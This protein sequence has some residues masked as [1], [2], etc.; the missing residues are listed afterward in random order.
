MKTARR[1]VGLSE[2]VL[3]ALDAIWANKLRSFLTV[4]GNI[5]AVSSIILVVTILQGV[6][7]EVT[8][9]L[10]GEGADVYTVRRRGIAFSHQE[11]LEM[12]ND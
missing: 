1:A 6:N 8:D 9:L 4:L 2:G 7:A 3:I 5:I 10:T 11:M 12:R